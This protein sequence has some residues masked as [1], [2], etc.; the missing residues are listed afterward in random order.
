[1][2]CFHSLSKRSNLPFSFVAGDAQLLKQFLLYRT[3]HG[4]AVTLRSKSQ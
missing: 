2:R 3:H 4:C 1:M